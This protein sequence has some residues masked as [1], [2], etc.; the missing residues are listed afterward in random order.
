M[1]KTEY[2]VIVGERNVIYFNNE[3]LKYLAVTMMKLGTNDKNKDIS[4]KINLE[5]KCIRMINLIL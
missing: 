4:N 3:K 1:T 2:L 5:K